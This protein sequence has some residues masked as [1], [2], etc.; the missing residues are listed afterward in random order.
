MNDVILLV[1]NGCCE[2]CHLSAEFAKTRLV[3]SC[4]SGIVVNLQAFNR[5]CVSQRLVTITRSAA[6]T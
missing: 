4:V 2:C 6:T 3:R 5:L 1:I